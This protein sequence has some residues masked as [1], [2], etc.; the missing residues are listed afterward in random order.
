MTPTHPSDT[1]LYASDLS[2]V[3]WELVRPLPPPEA[4]AGRPRLH[5]LHTILKANLHLAIC[6][7]LVAACLA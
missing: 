2:A 5:S 4:P 1:L 6:C 3:E 7:A